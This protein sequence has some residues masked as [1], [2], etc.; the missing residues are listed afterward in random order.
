MDKVC[1]R[2]RDKAQRGGK[3]V[4]RIY[5]SH[6]GQRFALIDG[7]I[8]AEY[9]SDGEAHLPAIRRTTTWRLFGNPKGWDVTDLA[10]GSDGSMDAWAE[11][12][13]F[14]WQHTGVQTGRG[15]YGWQ[16]VRS[17]MAPPPAAE[18]ERPKPELV[19]SAVGLPG[20]S[21]PFELS[22]GTFVLQPNSNVATL[23]LER[24]VGAGGYRQMPL[25]EGNRFSLPARSWIRIYCP[26]A[27]G[28]DVFKLLT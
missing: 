2:H 12:H 22:E 4:T 13:L 16:E 1:F 20:S 11:D 6:A 3:P 26:N 24:S 28:V 7:M 15:L 8:H 21:A 17:P 23:V 27:D 18:P 5:K 9:P 14:A 19:M 25:S 10:F